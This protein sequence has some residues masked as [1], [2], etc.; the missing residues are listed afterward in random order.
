MRRAVKVRSICEQ[1]G[2]RDGMLE[3]N[4]NGIWEFGVSLMGGGLS[5][6]NGKQNVWEFGVP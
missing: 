3:S 5:E 6:S 2:I 1:A 4:D